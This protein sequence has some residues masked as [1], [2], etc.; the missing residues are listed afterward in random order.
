M[1]ETSA[2]TSFRLTCTIQD[3][4]FDIVSMNE[5]SA[6]ISCDCDWLHFVLTHIIQD[7]LSAW[8]KPQL[9]LHF[10]WPVLSRTYSLILSAWMKP[11]LI[12]A[13]TAI[14]FILSWPI[15]SRTY[16]QHEWNLSW[17][18][19][20]LHVELAYSKQ[21]CIKQLLGGPARKRVWFKLISTF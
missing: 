20:W 12:S 16:Y 14:D 3:I 10:V 9:I 21:G 2:D 8:M 1:N 4:F 11:Q 17:Y 18:Q 15:L 19:L 7:L 13:V 6:D 5:T